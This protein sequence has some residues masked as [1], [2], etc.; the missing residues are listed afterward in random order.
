MWESMAWEGALFSSHVSVL[1]KELSSA[2]AME[3]SS[4]DMSTGSSPHQR[5]FPYF[6]SAKYKAYR[7]IVHKAPVIS[8]S[9]QPFEGVL[10]SQIH[11]IFLD[12]SKGLQ[13]F[14]KLASIAQPKKEV[15]MYV[16][17]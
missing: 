4:F 8:I 2:V 15:G 1:G 7:E 3:M 10:H 14:Y 13:P 5:G 11:K 6:L 12:L 17:C 16:W 9:V